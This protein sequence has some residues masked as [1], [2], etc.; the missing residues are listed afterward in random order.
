MLLIDHS[1]EETVMS[2]D[3]VIFLLQHL[4]FVINWEKSVLTPVQETEF[5]DQTIN[6]VT[7]ELSLS[8]TKI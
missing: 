6:S 3:T 8:K 2:R 1:L 4:G 5:S 7:L